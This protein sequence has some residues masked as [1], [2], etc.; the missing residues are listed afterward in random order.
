MEGGG[1]MNFRKA[2]LGLSLFVI[3]SITTQAFADTAEVIPKGVFRTGVA[4][5]FYFPVDQAFKD[6]GTTADPA[7]KYNA[8]LNSRAFPA[9]APY[10]AIFG[11]GGAT[12]GTSHV[13]FEYD[14]QIYELGFQYGITDRLSAGIMVPYWF[15]K[16]NVTASVDSSTANLGFNPTGVGPPIIPIAAGGVR[17]TSAQIQQLLVSSFGYKPIETW[18]GDGLADIEAGVKY[19]YFKTND[20]RLA[21]TFGV[22]MPTGQGDDADSLVDYALGSGTWALLFYSQN[23]YTG[24]KDLVLNLSLKYEHYLPYHPIM[25]VPTD[26]NLPLTAN[27]E[28]VERQRGDVFI[29]EISAQYEFYKGFTAGVLYKIG[30]GLRDSVSGD[31]GLDYTQVE[32]QTDYREQ[33][34]VV[35]LGFNTLAFYKE[36]KFPV[37]LT[38]GIAYRNRFEG[39]NVLKSQYIELGLGIYF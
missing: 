17:A 7:Y 16:N 19:Q 38:A 36:N 6:D 25:R 23:D 13:S 3:L 34:F 30:V 2:I 10:D 18:K 29:G 31:G 11:P 24:V 8:N 32:L 5:K 28:T 22:R 39:Y 15:V 21:G 4:G 20:W 12:L 1:L 9:L 35:S 33:V 26:V 14:F 37:P 27:K